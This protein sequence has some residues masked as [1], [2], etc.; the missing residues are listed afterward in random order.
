MDWLP[1]PLH[2]SH[3]NKL[4]KVPCLTTED[5]DHGDWK[6]YPERQGFGSRSCEDWLLV[7]D[8]PTSDFQAF[9]ERWLFWAPL[10]Y[11]LNSGPLRYRDFTR[12]I[13]GRLFMHL[14][15]RFAQIS[16]NIS[17]HN[18]S[19]AL[20]RA[21]I[22]EDLPGHHAIVLDNTEDI[23]PMVEFCKTQCFVYNDPRGR[24][25]V[26]ATILLHDLSRAGL[27]TSG[28]AMLR[29]L[30]TAVVP[31]M[32]EADPAG[33]AR[34]LQ[35]GWCPSEAHMICHKFSTSFCFFI[36]QFDRPDAP[37]HH[38]TMPLDSAHQASDLNQLELY[39][40]CRET[41]CHWRNIKQ[42]TYTTAHDADVG[43]QCHGCAQVHLDEDILSSIL[44]T[45][46]IPLIKVTKDTCTL[47]LDRFEQDGRRPKFVAI[48]HVWSDGMGNLDRNA[49]PACQVARLA[50]FMARVNAARP[51]D[52]IQYCWLDTLCVPPDAAGRPQ[53]QVKAMQKMRD[54]YYY[55]EIVLVLEK[56]IMN[57]PSIGMSGFEVLARVACSS[58]MRRLWTL[59]EGLLAPENGLLFAFKDR[60]ENIDERIEALLDAQHKWIYVWSG[61]ISQILI[62]L[63]EVRHLRASPML[64]VR[65]F[66]DANNSEIVP[67]DPVENK[68]VPYLSAMKFRSTSVAT[69]EALCLA[70]LFGLDMDVVTAEPAHL[71]LLKVWSLIQR[72]PLS[73]LYWEMPRFSAIPGHRWAPTTMMLPF[74]TF[75]LGSEY[76]GSSCDSAAVTEEGLRARAK[77]IT[78]VLS[79]SEVGKE[80]IRLNINNEKSYYFTPHRLG[81]LELNSPD[82]TVRYGY[83]PY[84]TSE[85]TSYMTK[86]LHAWDVWG[87]N[88]ALIWT[89]VAE[90]G[91]QH[92]TL[93]AILVVIESLIPD[94]YLAHLVEGVT[95]SQEIHVFEGV[96]RFRGSGELTA[97]VKARAI[98]QDRLWIID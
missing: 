98:E 20:H 89:Q 32:V 67:G 56:W 49:L 30:G 66:S 31:N 4:P 96:A 73:L 78:F 87:P 10:E 68:F 72:V 22:L 47:H 35:C 94:G 42:S 15:P 84:A 39:S 83:S 5:Y 92:N 18:D 63:R 6:T 74:S 8:T 82:W 17:R 23:V 53:A 59:Q 88:F 95:V 76:K 58:W 65:Y 26:S 28:M 79:R 1:R 85:S 60:L 12:Q 54:V 80:A 34:L 16:P 21:M 33:K 13:K 3:A 40:T 36:S 44:L 64:G 25:L 93:P 37:Q 90:L 81:L 52:P 27:I 61:I 2:V 29:P 9:L 41:K 7:F 14:A 91:A 46:H 86:R 38:P 55:A 11:I 24:L 51:N 71:R 48:S 50:R 45:G 43:F 70:V 69:D 75:G 62:V 19:F 57:R 97:T 77:G